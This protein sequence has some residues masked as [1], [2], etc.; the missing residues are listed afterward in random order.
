M[1][2]DADP[3]GASKPAITSAFI[4]SEL[5]ARCLPRRLLTTPHCR[6]REDVCSQKGRPPPPSPR[7]P[8][9]DPYSSFSADA[10]YHPGARPSRCTAAQPFAPRC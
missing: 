6:G 7:A 2:G 9:S 1:S 3:H 8:S 10:R 5:P 4:N